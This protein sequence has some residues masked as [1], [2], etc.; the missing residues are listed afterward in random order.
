VEKLTYGSK[1]GWHGVILAGILLTHAPWL[2][3]QQSPENTEFFEKKIRPVLVERCYGCHGPAVNP[4][5]AGLR[6]DSAEG[7]RK[8]GERGP[9][10]TPGDPESSRLIQAIRYQNPDLQMPPTGRLALE[11]IA[12][13][14]AWVKMGAPD[15]RTNASGA[16]ASSGKRAINLAQARRHWAFQQP[17]ERPVPAVRQES[18]VRTPVDRFILAKLE[19]KNVQPA[20]PADRAT[21]I[22]RV[23][24]DLIGLPPT[25]EEVDAFV[26]DSSPDA[27]RKVVERLLAS[28]HY[29]ERWARH[30]LDLVRYAETDGHEFDV[31]KPYAWRYRDYVI[32]AFN[33]DL[34]YKQF[35]TEQIA[36]D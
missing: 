21:L 35:V 28:P 20:P 33:D 32:R 10:I 12:D 3:A 14:E 7:W 31:D 2:A 9:E 36:G 29:G 24:F 27:Y 16:T 34:P 26:Q 30:W 17:K 6:L 8:G 13:F 23:T 5:K 1:I 4:P 19:E 18:W 11:Q 22:R 25:P 15:P